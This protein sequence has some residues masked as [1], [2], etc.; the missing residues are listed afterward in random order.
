[1]WCFI[2]LLLDS[3]VNLTNKLMPTLYSSVYGV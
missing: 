3:Q 2:Y 1:M